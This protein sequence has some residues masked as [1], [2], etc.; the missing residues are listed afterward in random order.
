VLAVGTETHKHCG[1]ISRHL[2]QD[3]VNEAAITR[4]VIGLKCW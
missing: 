1:G 4:K 2:G 3:S